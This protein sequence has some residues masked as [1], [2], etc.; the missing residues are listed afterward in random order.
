M[1]E[2]SNV[3]KRIVCAFMVALL[4]STTA[5]P[6]L[7]ATKGATYVVN[8]QYPRLRAK[9]QSGSKV[10]TKLKKGTKVTFLKDY[11]GWWKIQLA[12]GK[13]G[14]MYKDFLTFYSNA[15]VGKLYRTNTSSKTKV[16][17]KNSTSS[18]VKF[19]VSNKTT[20][21][22]L[23]KK[24]TWGLVRVVKNGAVGYIRLARL[25]AAK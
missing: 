2:K 25:K 18:R 22:L 6:A 16:Y 23:E 24:G 15:K 19:T 12:N 17:A 4:L 7:A 21:V 14:Y 3:F 13:T 9:P 1:K 11:N 5:I 8:A 10:L 20:L